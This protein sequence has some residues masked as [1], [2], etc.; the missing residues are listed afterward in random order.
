MKNSRRSFIRL[1]ASSAALLGLPFK[2]LISYDRALQEADRLT[3]DR[4]SN[5]THV[6]NLQLNPIPKVKVGFIGLGNRGQNHVHL[7]DALYPKAEIVSLC[8]IQSKKLDEAKKLIENQ[9]IPS[10]DYSNDASAWRDMLDNEELDLVIISTPWNSH[11]EMAVHAMENGIHVAVEVPI[12]LTIDDCW[13]LVDTAEKYRTHCMM[14]EN[15][16]YGRE[17]LW[18]LNMVKHGIFGEITHGEGAYIHDLKSLLFSKSYYYDYWRLRHHQT[19]DANLYP[20]H[21]L[22]PIAQYMDIGKG[23]RMQKLVSM[24][25]VS[26]S[27]DDYARHVEADHPFRDT[28]NFAHG[29][30]NTTM[31]QTERGRSIVLKH[32]VVTPRP[33]SRINALGGTHGYHEGYPSRLALRDN[34]NGHR[35]LDEKA[36]NEMRNKYNHPIWNELKEPIT[37]Y[38]GHGGMDF[39]QMY[40]LIDCLNRGVALDM[41]V[42]DAVDW[43]VVVPLSKLSIELGNIPI[44]IPDFRRGQWQEK[45]DWNIMK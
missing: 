22:G 28:S 16:C 10:P 3:R 15:V 19:T 27:L 1:S 31:I 42:Y 14:L 23:D 25:S 41:N 39:V 45:V 12:A 37:K 29:D 7:V 20:T 13:K 18:L 21:G 2:Q 17:E 9:V 11:V 32:D 30:I 8:D 40:R 44:S 34:S 5:A 6:K 36:L 26:K 43:S 4:P 38:G 24:S 33:Y 35:W